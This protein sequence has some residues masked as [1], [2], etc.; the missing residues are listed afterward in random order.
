MNLLTL[1]RPLALLILLAS[2]LALCS[3][4]AFA[5]TEDEPAGGEIALETDAP[6]D[7]AIAQRIATIFGEIDTLSAV[8]ITVEA[9]VVTLTGQTVTADAANRAETLALRVEG[10]VTVE[11]RIGRDVSVATR[12]APA[13]G[14]L[15]TTV[16][17]LVRVLPLLALA[18]LVFMALSFWAGC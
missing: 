13:V 18:V 3:A 5:Q 1:F 9:G 15:E 7:A 4:P 2:A 12:V 8:E 16:Q 10:V 14:E 17:D 11:N 6:S